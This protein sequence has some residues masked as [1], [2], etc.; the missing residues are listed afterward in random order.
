MEFKSLLN[1]LARRWRMGAIIFGAIF[2]GMVGCALLITPWYETSAKV[3]IT[4]PRAAAAA[5]NAFGLNTYTQEAAMSDDERDTWIGLAQMSPVLDEMS[6]KLNLEKERLRYRLIF[7]IPGV[8]WAINALGI[9]VKSKRLMSAKELTDSSML[10]YFMPYPHME[11]S[12][13]NSSN[14]IEIAAWNTDREMARKMA[15]ITAE[16]FMET[17]FKRV[18]QDYLDLVAYVDKNLE[19]ARAQHLKDLEVRRKFQVKE[20]TVSLDSELTALVTRMGD[21]KKAMEELKANLYRVRASIASMEKQARTTP[22]FQKAGEDFTRSS[23]ALN[24]LKSKLADQY[25]LLMD[26]QSKYAKNHPEL[27][28]AQAKVT[29]LKQLIKEEMGKL[30]NLDAIYSTLRSTLIQTYA[31][32]TGLEAQEKAWPLVVAGYER[33]M[34]AYPDRIAQQAMLDLNVKASTNVYQ[35]YQEYR[36]KLSLA[37]DVDLRTLHLAEPARMPPDDE[38]KPKMKTVLAIALLLATFFSF[39]TVFFLEFVDTTV[40]SAE[41]LALLGGQPYLGLVKGAFVQPPALVAVS[42]PNSPASE[43]VR[44]LRHGLRLSGSLERSPHLALA[45]TA[46]EEGKGFVAANLAAGLAGEGRRVLLMDGD[47]RAPSLHRFFDLDNGAGWSGASRQGQPLA[48]LCRPTRVEGLSLLCAGPKPEN[49]GRLVESPALR[50]MLAQARQEFDHVL[51]LGPPL[52]AASDSLLFGGQMGGLLLVARSCQTGRQ[53]LGQA[54]ELA[55]GARLDL[56]GVVL[57]F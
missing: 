47:L 56:A 28:T 41:D 7:A 4:R 2:F 26:A 48:Q 31:E 40:H 53:E 51:L 34:A 54:L 8:R 36:H 35:L 14:I 45:S 16:V 32:L 44:S 23:D 39:G 5:L 21:A 27:L 15:N 1:I 6:S 43:A 33:D 10:L 30:I 49:I 29:E 13:Y 50:E 20:K 37:G 17:E 55:R 52:L 9:Q 57:T 25:V 42:A 38:A 46:R 11:I 18:R 24:T 19:Q 22:E 3:V 12:Q